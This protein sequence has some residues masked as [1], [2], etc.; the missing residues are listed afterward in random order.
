MSRIRDIGEVTPMR[1][2]D[3]KHDHGESV[4]E[5]ELENAGEIHSDSSKEIV[6]S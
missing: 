1:A 3:Y 2:V 4:S 6:G 5:E